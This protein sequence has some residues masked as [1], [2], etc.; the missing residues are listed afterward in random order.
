[1]FRAPAMLMPHES[2]VAHEQRFVLEPQNVLICKGDPDTPEKSNDSINT[3][4]VCNF[5]KMVNYTQGL[6]VYLLCVYVRH[7]LFM[8]FLFTFVFL[9][10]QVHY[11]FL[12]IFYF[13]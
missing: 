11:I 6:I 13:S 10:W 7:M 2:T 12:L 3:A 8:R 5:K 1:M 9:F 4:R